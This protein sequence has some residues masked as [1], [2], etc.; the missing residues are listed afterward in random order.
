MQCV[1]GALCRE[2]ES[3]LM[4]P[5]QPYFQKWATALARKKMKEAADAHTGE[6]TLYVA[7]A[8]PMPASAGAE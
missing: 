6:R 3:K 4:V 8:P 7:W 5:L 2:L 1:G